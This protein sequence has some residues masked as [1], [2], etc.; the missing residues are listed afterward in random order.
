MLVCQRPDIAMSMLI[1]RGLKNLRISLYSNERNPAILD[2]LAHYN[3]DQSTKLINSK[4]KYKVAYDGWFSSYP[5]IEFNGS[6]DVYG[7]VVTHKDV[8]LWAEKF[9]FVCTLD[10]KIGA[11]SWTLSLSPRFQI[12]NEHSEIR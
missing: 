12:T 11:E 9:P 2:T 10:E 7:Y 4:W 8:L 1:K 6:K 5:E 3:I